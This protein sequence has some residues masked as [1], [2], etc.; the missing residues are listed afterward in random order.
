MAGVSALTSRDTFGSLILELPLR[1]HLWLC[2]L[3]TAQI[4]E[5]Q[6]TW[7]WGLKQ[8]L[9]RSH[10]WPDWDS[11]SALLIDGQV[12]KCHKKFS[13]STFHFISL[14]LSLKLCS[15]SCCVHLTL[16]ASYL[17]FITLDF[18]VD[19]C[20]HYGLILHWTLSFKWLWH[21]ILVPQL[22]LS[23]TYIWL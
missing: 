18:R 10:C 9:F 16:I 13:V 7:T 21:H 4:W 14:F 12:G 23:Y 20:L 1:C 2:K 6:F 5:A 19:T 3:Y 22:I 11:Y 17:V 8:L 15:P